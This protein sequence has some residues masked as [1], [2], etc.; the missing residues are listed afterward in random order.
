MGAPCR[1][2]PPPPRHRV[3][4]AHWTDGWNP[5]NSHTS[6]SRAGS[7]SIN[8]TR[9]AGNRSGLD[10]N[11]ARRQKSL[12]TLVISKLLRGLPGEGGTHRSR[13]TF[14]TVHRSFIDKVFVWTVF[15]CEPEDAGRYFRENIPLR[16]GCHT[17]K[18]GLHTRKTPDSDREQKGIWT[19]SFANISLIVYLENCQLNSFF[20]LF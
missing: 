20:L 18:W 3:P 8:T 1:T 11:L 9:G 14:I 4:R 12:L 7:G 5:G 13:L 15:I 17:G 6:R 2:S 19:V 10:V 16:C